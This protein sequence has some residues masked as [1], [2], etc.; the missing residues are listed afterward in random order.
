MSNASL[1][2]TLIRIKGANPGS[3]IAVFKTPLPDSLNAVFA[4]TIK[5]QQMIYGDHPDLIG[6][7][8]G[9]MD[10]EAVKELLAGHITPLINETA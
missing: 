2:H 9:T 5:T 6:V 4:S 3:P 7:F 10:M 1:E 8:D